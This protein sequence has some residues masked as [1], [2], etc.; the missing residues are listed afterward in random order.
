[1]GIG[2]PSFRFPSRERVLAWSLRVGLSSLH[3]AD[4]RLFGQM[5]HQLCEMGRESDTR[6]PRVATAMRRL[7]VRIQGR[8]VSATT[9][10]PISGASILSLLA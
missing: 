5:P 6:K 8:V 3:M 1:M 4:K 7:P 10:L 2:V 9:R